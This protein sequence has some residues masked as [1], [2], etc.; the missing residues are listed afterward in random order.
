MSAEQ[1]KFLVNL[2]QVFTK[3]NPKTIRH[4]VFWIVYSIFLLQV[5]NVMHRHV[6]NIYETLVRLLVTR[7][8]HVEQVGKEELI[9]LLYFISQN[10]TVISMKID[11]S[12]PTWNLSDE[13]MARLSLHKDNLKGLSTE[14]NKIVFQQLDL[15]SNTRV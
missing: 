3:M 12:T 14:I 1:I 6:V 10:S 13:I 5:D 7:N 9:T 2:N 8:V 15:Y 11:G 4:T